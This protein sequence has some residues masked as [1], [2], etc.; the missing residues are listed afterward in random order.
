MHWLHSTPPIS[1]T[2]T[3]V[4]LE[5]SSLSATSVDD[6]AVVV[7]DENGQVHVKN[8]MDRGVKIG[9]VSG[10][11]LGLLIAGLF[12]PVAGLVVG[13]CENERKSRDG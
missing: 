13:T 3:T 2:H 5:P 4:A 11:L 12:F 8:T 9:A 6:S 7:R 1:K 10:G